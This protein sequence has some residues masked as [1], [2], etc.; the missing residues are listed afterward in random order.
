MNATV[1]KVLLTLLLVMHLASGMK[2][3]TFA[4]GRHLKLSRSSFSF[5]Q[6][7]RCIQK[8]SLRLYS[9]INDNNDNND[10]NNKFEQSTNKKPAGFGRAN[11]NNMPSIDAFAKQLQL[12]KKLEGKI[13][14]GSGEG[15]EGSPTG[16]DGKKVGFEDLI[17]E[18]PSPFTI[19]VIGKK[20]ATLAIDIV[21]SVAATIRVI[22]EEIQVSTRDAKGGNWLSISITPTFRNA[23]EIYSVY[24]VIGKDQRVKFVI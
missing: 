20:D 18:F 21:N 14:G 7:S 5:H 24:E 3:C 19:K 1:E 12:N 9:N 6:S 16:P 22:P 2:S 8:P 13:I 4:C 11:Q 10:N 23:A 17:K 15:K